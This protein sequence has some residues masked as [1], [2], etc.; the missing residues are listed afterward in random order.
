[1]MG[2]QVGQKGQQWE[3]VHG[4]VRDAGGDSDQEGQGRAVGLEEKG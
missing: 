4:Q 3:R 1:M 2:R